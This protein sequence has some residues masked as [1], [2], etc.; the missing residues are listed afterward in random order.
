MAWENSDIYLWWLECI[1]LSSWT[2][3]ILYG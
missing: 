1:V 2:F 3:K